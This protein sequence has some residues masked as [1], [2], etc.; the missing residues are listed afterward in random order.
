[1]GPTHNLGTSQIAS[2]DVEFH[3]SARTKLV[4]GVNILADAV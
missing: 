3:D 4:A 2:K 1:M